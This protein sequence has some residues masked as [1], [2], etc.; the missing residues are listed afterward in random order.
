MDKSRYEIVPIAVARDG[1]WYLLR[2]PSDDLDRVMT[3]GISKVGEEVVL[4]GP[5]RR[6]LSLQSGIEL[7]AMDVAFPV[8]HGPYGEDGTVQ[9]MLKYANIP[10]V[11][12][13]VLGSALGMDKEAMKHALSAMKIPIA[14][15]V[16]LYKHV[17][18]TGRFH[19]ISETLG[20]PLF[21][22][23]ANMGSSVGVHKITNE[24]EFLPALADAFRFDSKVLVEEMIQGR[25]IECSILGNEVPRSS[26]LG[27]IIPQHSFYTYQAKYVD[28]AGARLVAP[29]DL[30]ESMSDEIRAL[31]IRVFK[32]LQCEGMGRVDFF[33]TPNNE[34]VVNEINTIP[35]FTKVS[36]YPKL[37]ELSGLS[38]SHLIDELIGLALARSAR[39]AAFE[40]T[41]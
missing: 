8:L 12:P 9:G 40:M 14:R 17:D 22:K 1:R 7:A 21:V 3:Q 23:P 35:G 19:E 37:W 30:P 36:M 4:G 33:L 6:L 39:E 31:A 32:T 20:L 28:E 15:F 24:E 27:E 29:A 26:I 2:Y 41:A 25:E 38:Y 18:A 10:F 11:G 5:S 13:G 16:T 34:I